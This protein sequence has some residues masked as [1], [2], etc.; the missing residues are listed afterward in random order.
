MKTTLD[1]PDALYR[2]FKMKT[3]MNGETIRNATLAFIASYVNG[4]AVGLDSSGIPQEPTKSEVEPELPAWA[5]LAAPYIRKNLDG[6]HDMAS[7]RR[8]MAKARTGERRS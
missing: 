6:P 8:S 3:A 4:R 7:I 1:I 5:G 2:R